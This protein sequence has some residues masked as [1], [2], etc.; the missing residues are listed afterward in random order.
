M[1]RPRGAGV[2]QGA[3]LTYAWPRGAYDVRHEMMMTPAAPELPVDELTP[4]E[5][6]PPPPPPLLIGRPERVVLAEYAKD[7]E[8]KDKLVGGLRW[9]HETQYDLDGLR[10]KERIVQCWNRIEHFFKP[11]TRVTQVTTP[12]LDEYAKSRLVEGAARQTVNNELSALRR[13]FNLGIEKGLLA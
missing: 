7:A 11:P 6:L 9:L 8:E 3:R 2:R 1:R 5:P 10:S 12:R 13:A 4:V